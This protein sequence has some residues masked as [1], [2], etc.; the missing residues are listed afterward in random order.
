MNGEEKEEKRQ[1]LQDEKEE[2]TT[3]RPCHLR[4][5][6]TPP[7]PQQQQQFRPLNDRDKESAAA[8]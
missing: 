6:S 4:I 2:M 8:S 7:P 1:F 5:H 3:H